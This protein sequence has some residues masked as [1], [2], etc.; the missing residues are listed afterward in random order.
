MQSNSPLELLHQFFVKLGARYVVVID[1]DGFCGFGT[2]MG[3]SHTLIVYDC[4]RRRCYRQ[5]D[6]ARFPQ[7]IGREILMTMSVLP[8]TSSESCSLHFIKRVCF[9]LFSITLLFYSSTSIRDCLI[10]LYTSAMT[11]TP[12]Y[13]SIQR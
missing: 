5:E 11:V 3:R 4:D 7:R 1:T 9:S 10:S 12:L 6:V 2:S 13:I 8:V